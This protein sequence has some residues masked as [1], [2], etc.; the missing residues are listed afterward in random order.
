MVEVFHILTYAGQATGVIGLRLVFGGDFC[1]VPGIT[2]G[3]SL[4]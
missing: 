2:Q 4:G 1:Q 3:L